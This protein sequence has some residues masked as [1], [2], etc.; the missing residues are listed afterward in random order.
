MRALA[1]PSKPPSVRFRLNMTFASRDFVSGA[2]SLAR[3]TLHKFAKEQH[4]T[5][6]TCQAVLRCGAKKRS[7]TL[8]QVSNR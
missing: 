1:P 2:I 7:G 4:P 8:W 5:N 3:R 6:D